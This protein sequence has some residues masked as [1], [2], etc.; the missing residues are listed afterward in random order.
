[1]LIGRKDLEDSSDDPG[2]RGDKEVYLYRDCRGT[3]YYGE[4]HIISYTEGCGS[5]SSRKSDR[6]YD[7]SWNR[8]YN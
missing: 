7:C 4:Q 8:F 6:K 5:S 2:D 1:M 3:S